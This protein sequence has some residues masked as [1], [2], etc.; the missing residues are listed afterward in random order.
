MCQQCENLNSLQQKTLH[1]RALGFEAMGKFFGYPDCCIKW[2]IK[3]ANNIMTAT[4]EK[5]FYEASLIERCQE[6]FKEGF[7]PCP[8]CAKKVAPGTEH[9]LI[10]DRIHK[11]AYPN[12]NYVEEDFDNYFNHFLKTKQ[13]AENNIKNSDEK[14]IQN[15]NGESS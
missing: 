1:N 13:D 15:H 2:F 8:E 11:E 10:K 5:G 4:S 6:G 3:R 7:V 14:S 12:D 9:Q